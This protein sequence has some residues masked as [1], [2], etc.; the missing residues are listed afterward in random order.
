[1]GNEQSRN[2]E[3]STEIQWDSW[4]F[5]KT[6][7]IEKNLAELT[8]RKKMKAKIATLEMK[9]ETSWQIPMKF[10]RPLGHS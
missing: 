7:E 1:M 9:R 8:R 5:E 10:T 3:N 6:K 4:L 2:W